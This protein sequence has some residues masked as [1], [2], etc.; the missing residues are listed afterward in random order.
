M[1]PAELTPAQI[2]LIVTAALFLAFECLVFVVRGRG[3]S[4]LISHMRA[5][6]WLNTRVLHRLRVRGAQGDPLPHS[7]ACIVV[8]NHQCGAD[9][10]FLSVITRRPVRFLMAREYYNHWL[11]RWLFKRLRCIPVNRDG[12]DLRATKDALKALHDGECI[13]IFPQGGI[14]AVDGL[15]DS[16]NGVALLAL[17]TGATIVPFYIDTTASSEGVFRSVFLPSRTRVYCGSPTALRPEPVRKPSREEIEAA[18]RTILESIYSLK[19]AE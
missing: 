10:V 2:V 12:N 19:P 17:R 7:G 13:G 4:V 14:R 16:K 6:A 11:F 9:P 5:L 8:A 1:I 3:E 15:E 18:T